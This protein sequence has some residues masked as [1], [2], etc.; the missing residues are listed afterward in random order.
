MDASNSEAIVFRLTTGNGPLV[1]VKFVF[2]RITPSYQL[3]MLSRCSI[4]SSADNS[5][6]N[7]ETGGSEPGLYIGRD[8]TSSSSTATGSR[9]GRAGRRHREGGAW[10][11]QGRSM[12]AVSHSRRQRVLTGATGRCRC[13]PVVRHV[14]RSSPR[15]R[16]LHLIASDVAVAV[17]H[18]GS[19]ANV[20]PRARM[21]PTWTPVSKDAQCQRP[22]TVDPRDSSSVRPPP[23]E[24]GGI[25]A[26]TADGRRS[27]TVVTVELVFATARSRPADIVCHWPHADGFATFFARKI[28][29][30]WSDTAGLSPPQAFV[31]ASS[32]LASFRPCSDSEVRRLIMS[33][34]VKSSSLDP[35][36]TFSVDAWVHRHPA[37]LHN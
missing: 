3:T 16:L 20:D 23:S 17:Y 32:S 31:A 10:L 14:R 26:A 33:S 24:E 9:C 30:V 5:S 18:R 36:P 29:A 21:P 15:Y 25:L 35:I 6:K 7:N 13:W 22:S 27:L 1:V 4:S 11:V 2:C 34:P 19:T 12:W 37:A 28:D 8:R